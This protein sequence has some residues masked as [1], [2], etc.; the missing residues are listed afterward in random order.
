MIVWLSGGHM[1]NESAGNAEKVENQREDE[2]TFNMKMW[3]TPLPPKFGGVDIDQYDLATIL[4][5][6][7]KYSMDDTW[8]ERQWVLYAMLFRCSN[9]V[10][11]HSW[12]ERIWTIQEGAC[13]PNAPIFYFHGHTFS[14]DDFIAAVSIVTRLTSDKDKHAAGQRDRIHKVL[15]NGGKHGFPALFP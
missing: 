12:W 8:N 7:Q 14:F 13:P 15:G 5:K 9:L 3:Y 4:R 10:L 11:L 1:A 6:A 2:E